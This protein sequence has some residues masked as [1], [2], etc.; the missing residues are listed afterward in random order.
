MKLIDLEPKW[1]VT[2]DGRHGM[3]ITFWCPHCVNPDRTFKDSG[4]GRSSTTDGGTYLGVWFSNPIDGGPQAEPHTSHDRDAIGHHNSDSTP[5]WNR[6]GDTFDTLTLSPS[7]DC[8]RCGHW[9]GFIRN[10]EVT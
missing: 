4:G 10:G 6:F 7:I 9:H 2:E 3:G 8:S 1:S 5:H